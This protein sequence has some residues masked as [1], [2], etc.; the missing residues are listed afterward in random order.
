MKYGESPQEDLREWTTA[1]ALRVVKL[2]GALP[3]STEAQVLGK[4]LL[5]SGNSV[6]ANYREAHR[7]AQM[8][9]QTIVTW[10]LLSMMPAPMA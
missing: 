6:G 5:R 2:F 7:G 4:Q 3:K 1:F 8:P 10:T 9:I